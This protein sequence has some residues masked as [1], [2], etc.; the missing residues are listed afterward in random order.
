MDLSI[1][2]AIGRVASEPEPVAAGGVRQ[3]SGAGTPTR[4]TG[5]YLENHTIS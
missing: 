5:W 3:L 1:A 4:G 2:I